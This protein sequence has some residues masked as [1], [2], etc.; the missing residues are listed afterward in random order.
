MKTDGL[1]WAGAFG[2]M[3][4]PGSAHA[5][6]ADD[7]FIL[8]E[9]AG[10]VQNMTAHISTEL[11]NVGLGLGASTTHWSSNPGRQGMMLAVVTQWILWELVLAF[12][13]MTL[14]L[15]GPSWAALHHALTQGTVT[16]RKWVPLF[17]AKWLRDGRCTCV[18]SVQWASRDG[19]W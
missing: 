1:A 3:A 17:R 10:D 8:E 12:V 9:N 5:A 2:P 16:L 13:G 18:T 11:Q 7:I 6:Y 15:S 19:C 14:D 4:C